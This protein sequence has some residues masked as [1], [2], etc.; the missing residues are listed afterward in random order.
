MQKNLQTDTG[1]Y[2]VNHQPLF[3]V[4]DMPKNTVLIKKEIY[5]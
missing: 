5:Q 2:L 1:I 3:Y 4:E